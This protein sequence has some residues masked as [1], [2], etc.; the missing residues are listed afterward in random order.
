[1]KT[2]CLL[3]LIAL[4]SIS[5]TCQSGPNTLKKIS[6]EEKFSRVIY[7]PVFFEGKRFMFLFDT[8]SKHSS[9]NYPKVSQTVA[10]DT[11]NVYARAMKHLAKGE[12]I[13]YSCGKYNCNLGGNLRI[14]EQ[15]FFLYGV[16]EKIDYRYDSDGVIGM[17][18]ISNYNWLFDFTTHT[19]CL[20][21]KGNNELLPQEVESL[22]LKKIKD[23]NKNKENFIVNVSLNDSITA[24]FLFQTGLSQGID[25]FDH[26]LMGD[27]TLTDSLYRYLNKHYG[28]CINIEAGNA[29]IQLIQSVILNNYKMNDLSAINKAHTPVNVFTGGFLKRFDKMYYDAGKNEVLLFKNE[30]PH[31]Y[32]TDEKQLILKMKEIGRND[33]DSLDYYNDVIVYGTTIHINNDSTGLPANSL[34]KE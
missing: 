34:F 7:V 18:I 23:K 8:G 32:K 11:A 29:K 6:Y 30:S 15:L 26:K 5:A 16:G 3:I 19:V 12:K 17:D 22:K 4:Y 24:D 2:I 13:P 25:V 27:M 33:K 14:K 21:P 9:I 31:I 20:S 1:M 28:N 10:L